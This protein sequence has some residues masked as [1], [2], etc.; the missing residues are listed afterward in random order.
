MV[1]KRQNRFEKQSISSLIS[2]HFSPKPTTAVA[3]LQF[4]M[5]AVNA[6]MWIRPFLSLYNME[7][8]VWNAIRSSFVNKAIPRCETSPG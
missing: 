6:E 8:E 2:P 1:E 7:I 3:G 5:S 4:S